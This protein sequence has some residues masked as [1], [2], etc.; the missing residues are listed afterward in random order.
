[1][2]VLGST[3]RKTIV[4]NLAV[5]VLQHIMNPLFVP[6]NLFALGVQYL[7]ATLLATIITAY[8]SIFIL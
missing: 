3:R 7:F 4:K 5:I 2:D 6:L 1:M 8:D